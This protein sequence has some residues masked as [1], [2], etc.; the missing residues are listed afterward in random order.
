MSNFSDPAFKIKTDEETDIYG[1]FIIEPMERGYGHTIGN[2]LRRV[3]LVSLPGAAVTTVKIEGAKHQFQTLAGLKEDIVELILNIKKLRVKLSSVDKATLTL[4]ASGPG[5]ITAADIQAPSEVEVVNKDLVL[6]NLTDKKSDLNIEMVVEKGYGYSLGEE[7]KSGAVGV[8]AVDASFTPVVRVNYLVESTRVGRVTDYDRLI[9]E[10]WTD[11]TISPSEALKT[12]SKILVSYFLQIYEP[13][14]AI[15]DVNVAVTPTVSDDVLKMLVEELD[16]P[17]R[18]ENALKNG[19][20]ETVGQLLGTQH[21]DLL[22]I[23]NFGAKS[24]AVVEEKLREKGVAL[25]I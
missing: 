6:A 10:I 19:G 18:L 22:R 16:L 20:I 2:S 5:V 11:G 25:S 23:K 1:R 24:L 7:R 3:L 4:E 12:A 13:R 17:V 14:V 8:L 9:I 15:E 21:K